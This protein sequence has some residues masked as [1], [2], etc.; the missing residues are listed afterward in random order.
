M[1]EAPVRFHPKPAK[2]LMVLPTVSRIFD[3]LREEFNLSARASQLELA[4]T[5][6]T[7]LANGGTACIE[8]PTGTG[9]T[10]GYLAGAIEAQAHSAKPIPI[11]VATATVGLQAQIIKHDIPRLAAVGA[12]DPRKVAVAKGRGRYFCPRTAALLQDKKMQDSQ[13]DIFATD[14]HVSD[15]GVQ[16]ALDMLKAW[17][18]KEW[19]GDRDSWQGSIPACWAESCGASSDTCVN[20]AC[21]YYSSCPYMASRARLSQAQVIIANHDI[22]LADLQQR[23]QE[24]PNTV[25]PT[26]KYSLIFDEAHNLPE[27]AIGTKRAVARLHATENLRKLEQ[28][29]ERVLSIPK[30]AKTLE[31]SAGVGADVF[32][33][34]A[35]MLAAGMANVTK[36]LGKTC[37]FGLDGNSSWGLEEPDA[38]IIAA[39]TELSEHSFTLEKALHSAAKAY[40]DL[41]ESAVGMEKNFAVR[42]LAETY[43]HA[44]M[45]NELHSGFMRFV[46]DEQLVRWAHRTRDGGVELHT[47]PLEGQ[48]VLDKLLWSADIPVAMVS[49]T[50]QIAG[51]FERFRQKTG[52]PASATT[53]ALP[54]VFDYTR[55]FLH[56][57]KMTTSPV[58]AGFEAELVV[59]LEKLVAKAV[60]PGMLIL[61]TSRESMRRVARAL[62][63]HISKD[64][65]MQDRR[66]VQELVAQHRETIDAGRRSILMG[67]DSMAEGLD[68][69]GKYC[70]HVIMTRLPFA[71][72]SDPVEAARRDYL[73]A[74]RWF[75][76]AYLADMLTMLIQSCGRLIRRE[77]DHGVITVLDKRLTTKEYAKTALR[78]LPAFTRGNLT[79]QY[80][81]MAAARGFE[82]PS[83]TL[84]AS[85]LESKLADSSVGVAPA[86]I[87]A[88]TLGAIAV[89]TSEVIKLP[90]VSVSAA[91]ATQP[92]VDELEAPLPKPKTPAVVE[93]RI[94]AKQLLR[95]LARKVPTKVV[96]PLDCTVDTLT[97][98][99]HAQYPVLRGDLPEQ[100][101]DCLAECT[102]PCLPPGAPAMVWAVRNMPQA[103]QLALLALNAAWDD[104][105]L[106]WQKALRLRPDLLQFAEVL[107]SQVVGLLDDRNG[108]LPEVTCRQ[109]LLQGFA[110]MSPAPDDNELFSYLDRINKATCTILTQPHRAPTQSFLKEFVQVG[111]TVTRNLRIA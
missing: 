66:P 84:P 41:A 91:P 38:D 37:K 42:Q 33:Y 4:R 35:A 104:N 88:T 76:E 13:F 40:A 7:T 32:S 57:P 68:L 109:Q 9:K 78:A 12:V 75:N 36:L 95:T 97:E 56:T 30:I 22:V 58:E 86:P 28:Y 8:A 2:A 24:S 54:P 85:K 61:F 6:A 106:P 105:A 26:A 67:L 15:G 55:G 53:L 50:L 93:E 43:K 80:F 51:S 23:A 72:P 92:K 45:V 10:L 5:V 69:P 74:K 59:K 71:V 63:D 48:E 99:M 49:A 79:S 111:L 70:G 96:A 108:A 21:D 1:L 19:D 83:T 110:G 34:E 62:P 60:S 47:Q 17:Q 3:G 16:I 103:N 44:R 25:I 82:M 39:V 11:V 101:D 94:N 18:A 81:V 31:R 20:K 29:G 89:S 77:D 107:R 27:K 65:L 14:K 90:T 98:K 46:D 102:L 87:K 64:V 52:L 100:D 73:G